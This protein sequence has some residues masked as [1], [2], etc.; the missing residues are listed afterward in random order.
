MK[1]L[2]WDADSGDPDPKQVKGE[3]VSDVTR[4]L[5]PGVVV[6][7]HMNGRG[8]HTAEALPL[9]IAKM[10]TR[11]YTFVKASQL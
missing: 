1:T 6:L 9:L 8:W 3:I 5:R 11:G 7:L 4:H 2:V 10:R